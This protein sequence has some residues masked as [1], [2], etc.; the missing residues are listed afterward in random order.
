MRVF[1]FVLGVAWKDSNISVSSRRLCCR[2]DKFSIKFYSGTAVSC[3]I[4]CC[5]CE[6]NCQ[7]QLEESSILCSQ[8]LNKLQVI[9][10][11]GCS[12]HFQQ[13]PRHVVFNVRQYDPVKSFS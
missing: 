1:G 13:V 2:S 3:G 10:K 9:T 5:L 12:S 6:L 11:L 8:G 7:L 4:V